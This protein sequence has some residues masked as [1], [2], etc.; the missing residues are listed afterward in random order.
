M[1]IVAHNV[2]ISRGSAGRPPS[3]GAPLFPELLHE[4]FSGSAILSHLSRLIDMK[5]KGASILLVAKPGYRRNSISTSLHS[6]P[7]VGLFVA[8][9]T[10][11]GLQLLRALDPS[12]IL[13]DSTSM[14]GLDYSDFCQ[15][16][17]R[18]RPQSQCF[19][20]VDND[21]IVNEP[22]RECLDGFIRTNHSAYEFVEAVKGLIKQPKRTNQGQ[23]QTT[24]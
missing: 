2:P 21:N 20:L 7:A 11:S 5:T 17:K 9:G 18:D 12:I 23:I 19:L 14:N 10:A 6:I 24:I 16:V 1:N 3:S 13:I 22:S 15:S 8:D 4:T